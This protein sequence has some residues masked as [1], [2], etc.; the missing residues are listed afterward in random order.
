VI[1]RFNKNER[2]KDTLINSIKRWEKRLDRKGARRRSEG[3]LSAKALLNSGRFKERSNKGVAK[4]RGMQSGECAD[5]WGGEGLQERIYRFLICRDKKKTKKRARDSGKAL[6]KKDRKTGPQPSGPCVS[7]G[8][9][10]KQLLF[11]PKSTRF[12]GMS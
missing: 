7:Q 1:L 6:Q 10:E 5:K 12:E 11:A 4:R 2:G 8:G 3:S 9:R